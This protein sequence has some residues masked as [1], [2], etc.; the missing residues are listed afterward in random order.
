MEIAK[1]DVSLQEDVISCHADDPARRIW[2]SCFVRLGY[3]GNTRL[4][5]LL[6]EPAAT[7]LSRGAGALGRKG[8]LARQEHWVGGV[9][10]GSR[11]TG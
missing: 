5:D 10:L 8:E 6:L 11:S 7:T 3:V 2:E 9:N 4:E 1:L